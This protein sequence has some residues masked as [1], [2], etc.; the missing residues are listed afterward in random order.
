VSAPLIWIF[1]PAVVAVF[2][3]LIR[4]WKYIILLLGVLCSLILA[5][6]ALIVPIGE[7]WVIGSQT[8]NV[9]DTLSI[10]GRQFII[11]SSDTPI[12]ILIYVG[13]A[14]WFGGTIMA[15]VNSLFVPVGLVIASLS[16]A[17]LAV[18]PFLYAALFIEMAVLVSVPILV[19]PGIPVGKGVLRFI[20]FETLGV[21]FILLTGWLIA[22]LVASPVDTEVI[23][24]ANFTLGLGFALMLGIFPFYTWIPMITE[25]THPYIAAFILFVIPVLIML[26]GLGLM[27]QYIWLRSSAD[28][29]AIFRIAG[30]GMVI[31]GGLWGAFQR[32]LGRLIGFAVMSEIGLSLLVIGADVNQNVA[33]PLLGIFFAMLVPWG[34]SLG[35]WALAVATILRAKPHLTDQK[36]KLV[37]QDIKGLG[38]E[39]P[40]AT[41]GVVVAIFSL[42]GLPLLAGFPPRLALWN[43]LGDEYLLSSIG[44]LLGSVGLM[45]GGVR[46]L[47]A[48]VK[49]P[50]ENGIEPDD[51]I[52]RFAETRGEVILLVLGIVAVI[53]L[54]LFPQW[55]T[56]L[57][58]QMADVYLHLGL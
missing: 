19:S 14:F 54:G 51:E 40:F 4:R 38:W 46:T 28:L 47:I 7:P 26:F 13:L 2:L 33:I 6:L 44:I 12:L 36:Y 52:R 5:G 17:V 9:S 55:L 50:E 24:M 25:E 34:L 18:E 48:L 30:L 20:T 3:A 41:G 21:P 53:L 15:D 43:G 37:F 49:A 11:Q 8:V 58:S 42:A 31:V 56:S 29:Y 23:L 1:T 16:T 22:G 32:S 57:L 35:L 45:V 10:L 39:L 27:D